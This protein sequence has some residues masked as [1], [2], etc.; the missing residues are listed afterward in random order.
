MTDYYYFAAGFTG[1]VDAV[2][3]A[4]PEVRYA[5]TIP[6]GQAYKAFF[7]VEATPT[8]DLGRVAQKLTNQGATG[9]KRTPAGKQWGP[10]VLKNSQPD[11]SEAWTLIKVA[12]QTPSAVGQAVGQLAGVPG[13]AEVG[14]NDVGFNVLANAAAGDDTAL[15]AVVGTVMAAAGVDPTTEHPTVGAKFWRAP[16]QPQPNP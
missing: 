10:N 15:G 9:L 5:G 8:T 4:I 3:N 6:N 13:V 2:H 7:L 12:G 14:F 16:Q 1:T 11:T